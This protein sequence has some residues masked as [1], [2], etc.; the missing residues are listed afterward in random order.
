M[1]TLTQNC[2]S[3]FFCFV[4]W[5]LICGIS[6]THRIFLLLCILAHTDVK[7]MWYRI[8]CYSSYLYQRLLLTAQSQSVGKKK[9]HWIFFYVLHSSIHQH[10]AQCQSK[11][12][13][14]FTICHNGGLAKKNL[15]P[16]CI[17]LCGVK[18]CRILANVRSLK[19]SRR[20]R[21]ED[22]NRERYWEKKRQRAAGRRAFQPHL[23]SPPSNSL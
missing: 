2:V 5:K 16:F 20:E 15:R 6:A 11:K 4:Y 9:N 17:I 19:S 14:E 23:Y 1:L 13:N 7:T 12:E 21:E 22:S 10:D 8:H 18:I 3:I